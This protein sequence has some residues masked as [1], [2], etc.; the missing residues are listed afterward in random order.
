MGYGIEGAWRRK[1]GAA[2]WRASGLR[3]PRVKA[4]RESLASG[5]TGRAEGS[6]IGGE[7]D[8]GQAA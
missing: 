1:R 6:G 8:G 7:P 2:G 3:G 4:L 5:K